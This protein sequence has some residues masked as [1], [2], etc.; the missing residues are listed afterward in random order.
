M[1]INGL[2][3]Y[4]RKSL[5]RVSTD[6]TQA[7][8]NLHRSCDH[9]HHDGDMTCAHLCLTS[10]KS[11]PTQAAVLCQIIRAVYPA[12]KQILTS[13]VTSASHQVCSTER[14]CPSVNHD[15]IQLPKWSLFQKAKCCFTRRSQIPPQLLLLSSYNHLSPP[16]YQQAS[17]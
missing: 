9:D 13:S 17:N 3:D 2:F 1:L 5:V 16:R 12:K 14:L 8:N 15:L 4:R 7:D 11:C 6:W 10:I